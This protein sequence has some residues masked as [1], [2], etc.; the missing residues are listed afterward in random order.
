MITIIFTCIF[1]QLLYQKITGL[2]TDLSGP[3]TQPDILADR[4]E[5]LSVN[6]SNNDNKVEVDHDDNANNESD[7]NEGSDEDSEGSERESS[8]GNKGTISR[9][10][11]ESPDSKKVR[12]HRFR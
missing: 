2:K 1:F 10:R 11:D 8:T 12:C 4:T 6:D 9:P 3:Q 7:N 5:K